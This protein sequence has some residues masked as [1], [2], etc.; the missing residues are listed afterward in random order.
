MRDNLYE[1]MNICTRLLIN[2]STPHL[3]LAALCKID[4]NVSRDA[5]RSI[6]EGSSGSGYT[7]EI[8]QYGAGGLSFLVT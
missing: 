5:Q 8:P 6:K 4:D 3:R 2:E 7:V 1:V